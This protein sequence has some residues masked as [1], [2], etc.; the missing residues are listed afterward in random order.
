VMCRQ[1]I[2]VPHKSSQACTHL[3]P[4]FFWWGKA[5]WRVLSLNSGPH[6]CWQAL[7]HL[8]HSTNP[9]CFLS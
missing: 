4:F 3:F 8:S 5:G 1:Q 7:Y 9:T 2:Q 6:T